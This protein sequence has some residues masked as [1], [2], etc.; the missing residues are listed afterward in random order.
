MNWRE[1]QN[2]SQKEPAVIYSEFNLGSE[3]L[4][5]RWGM[6]H[7]CGITP[8]T[9]INYGK[10]MQCCFSMCSLPKILSIMTL[11]KKYPKSSH[12][13][14]LSTRSTDKQRHIWR[15]LDDWR[16]RSSE[17]NVLW[18]LFV[19]VY[20]LTYIIHKWYMGWHE[21]KA[22]RY[23]ISKAYFLCMK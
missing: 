19:Y 6:Q 18:L 2:C 22:N 8:C 5:V 15:N 16:M 12:Q 17:L 7:C 3:F 1:Y 23:C 21:Y 4:I 10:N 11:R 14:N 13:Q 9:I 20:I